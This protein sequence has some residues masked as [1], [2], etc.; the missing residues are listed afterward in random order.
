[1]GSPSRIKVGIFFNARRQQGGLYQYAL[2]LVDCLY[3]FVPEFNYR[4]YHATLEEFPLEL[5]GANWKIFRLA[6]RAIQIRLLEEAVLLSAA[7]VGVG[8]PF[9][10][11][12]EFSEIKRD[13]PDLMLYVKPGVHPFQW[14]YKAIFPIHDLQH[15][16][17]PDFPE[18]SKNGEYRRR[19]YFYT[20]SIQRASAILTDSET[21]KDDVVSCYGVK[22]ESIF[23][24]PYIAPT[25]RNTDGQPSPTEYIRGKYSL[26]VQ[27]LFYPAAFWKHKNHARLVQA[28]SLLAQEKNVRIPLVLAGSKREEY[29]N[30]AFLVKSLGLGDIVHFIGY[31]PDED[32]ADLY[33]HALALVMPTFFGPT[34]IPVLEAWGS[35][36]AVITSDLRG[37]REQVGDAGLLVDPRSEHAIAEAIWSL[38]QFPNLRREL[39]ARGKTRVMEWTPEKFAFKLASAIR[40]SHS[41]R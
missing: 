38:Y 6:R 4:L 2:T 37:I 26:P 14:K 9:A 8:L 25:F 18:V 34:N 31:V 22:K 15:R 5:S 33:Q 19:E 35:E 10:L 7:R 24:V 40:Y 28:I 21:G 27:Y 1:M 3:R 16:L 39:I 12:T 23:P 36:C 17:Q 11:V 30:I 13:L 32:M 29:A 41:H 20:R